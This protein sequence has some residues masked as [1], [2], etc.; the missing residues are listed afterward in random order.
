MAGDP[1]G[2]EPDEYWGNAV[3]CNVELLFVLARAGYGG[4]SLPRPE[5][6]EGWKKDFMAVWE[7]TI[8]GLE[9]SPDYKEERR[10]VLHRTFDE[11]AGAARDV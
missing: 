2:I 3:P 11:L 4:S 6:V 1:V 9:P 8:D 10:T 5:V 7:A